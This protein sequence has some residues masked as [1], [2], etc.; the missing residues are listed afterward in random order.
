MRRLAATLLLALALLAPG[1]AGGQEADARP[2]DHRRDAGPAAGGDRLAAAA[3]TTTTGRGH[4]AGRPGDRQQR[5][6]RQHRPFRR[7]RWRFPPLAEAAGPGDR[8]RRRASTAADDAAGGGRPRAGPGRLGMMPV[9]EGGSPPAT[10]DAPTSAAVGRESTADAARAIPPPW[11]TTTGRPTGSSCCRHRDL[12]LPRP[13]SLSALARSPSCCSPAR[14]SSA[15]AASARRD[16]VD[17]GIGDYDDIVE[18]GRW[19]VL[20]RLP[21]PS[22]LVRPAG[23]NQGPQH[24]PVGRRPGGVPAGVRSHRTALRPPGIVTVYDAA[25]GDDGRCY[26][27]ME[28]L[29]GWLAGR[30]P[31]R[32]RPA[33]RRPRPAHRRGPGGG[34]RVG[35]PGRRRPR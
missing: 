1:A 2:A 30:A 17:P 32:G 4:D 11:T 27:V 14:R 12:G 19:H 33:R 26:L 28:L 6:R 13:L 31:R 15:R 22:A 34:P 29:D 18:I 20:H 3:E 24:A 21:G 5:R 35:P 25:S 7:N 23:R 9:T 16:V 8:P 10:M